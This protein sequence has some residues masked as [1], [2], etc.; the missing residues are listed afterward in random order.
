MSKFERPRSPISPERRKIVNQC[1]IQ[2]GIMERIR[3]GDITSLRG[4]FLAQGLEPDEVDYLM[5]LINRK[6]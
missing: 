1:L 4:E 3:N 5:E 2:V 6:A